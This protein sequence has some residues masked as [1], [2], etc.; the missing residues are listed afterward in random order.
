[1]GNDKVQ[2]EGDYDAAR[3]FQKDEKQFVEQHAKGG[4]TIEGDATAATD[5]PTAAEREG[6][7]RA[8]DGGQDERDAE[9]MRELEER[10]GSG[11]EA[12][13]SD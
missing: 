3:R 5:E 13:G 10:R 4:R 7:A 8:R 9:R 11:T 12:N 1:M 6:R 2:G